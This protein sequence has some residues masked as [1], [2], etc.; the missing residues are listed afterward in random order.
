MTSLMLGLCVCALVACASAFAPVL[1]AP[2]QCLA[3]AAR[4]ALPSF[5]PP[6]ARRNPCGKTC[7]PP[8]LWSR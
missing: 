6:G 4:P 7:P 2:R 3:L 5:L 1:G 8:P